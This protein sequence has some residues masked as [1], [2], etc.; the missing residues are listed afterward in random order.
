M[1]INNNSI[2][3]V[4]IGLIKTGTTAMQELWYKDPKTCLVHRGILPLV[5]KAR[6][7]A[8]PKEMKG[9]LPVQWQFDQPPGPDQHVVISQEVLS[10]AYINERA[11]RS[12]VRQFQKITARLIRQVAPDARILITV[13]APEPWIKSAYNQIV[14][15]GSS[16]S[17]PEFLELERDFIEQSLNVRDLVGIW[18]ECFGPGSVLVLPVELM[19]QD[20]EKFYDEIFGFS[21]LPA[22]P[23]S[24]TRSANPSL[25]HEHLKFMR[26]FNKW[27]NLFSKEGIYQDNLPPQVAHALNIV[28]YGVYRSLESSSP[29]L[30]ET[31]EEVARHLPDCQIDTAS[32]DPGFLSHIKGFYRGFLEREAFRDFRG[33]Y[34]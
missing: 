5:E 12:E 16:N 3:L 23:F 24:I 13:R 19:V 31:I 7:E 34:G 18:E 28:R 4:H 6:Q 11:Q 8:R 30:Q 27:A 25:S 22:P 2:R 15:Q 9:S 14:K 1:N 26:N 33:L 21:G 17:F 10:T 20:R 32:I 29:H